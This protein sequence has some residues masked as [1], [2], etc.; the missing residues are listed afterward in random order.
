MRP[1]PPGRWELRTKGEES[2][3]PRSGHLIEEEREHLQRRRVRP[4]QIFPGAV[5]GGPL[6]FLDDPRHQRRLGLLLLLLGALR[7]RWSAIRRGQREQGGQQRQS[8]SL[9]EAV[10]T[11]GLVKCSEL[12][13]RCIVWG[14]V[15]KALQVVDY[16]VEGTVLVIG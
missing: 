8:I 16:W 5:H 15:Q 7:Q 4:M 9:G 1:R 14:K 2:Q 10:G 3:Q 11:Q 6:S 12:G 13:L